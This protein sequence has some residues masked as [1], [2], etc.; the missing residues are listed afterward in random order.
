MSNIRKCCCADSTCVPVWKW[1]HDCEYEK[2]TL[3]ATDVM[4]QNMYSG[5]GSLIFDN[6]NR[7]YTVNGVS[8]GVVAITNTGSSG[9][10]YRLGCGH[11]EL[12]GFI[13]DAVNYCGK[14]CIC[15]EEALDAADC[16]TINRSWDIIGV[17]PMPSGFDPLGYSTVTNA[18]SGDIWLG[19]GWI[20]AT[21]WTAYPPASVL[22]A[23]DVSDCCQTVCN[24]QTY[25]CS[26]WMA[27]SQVNY[28]TVAVD[29]SGL[30]SSGTF[31][32][33]P[34]DSFGYTANLSYSILYSYVSKTE[35]E[36]EI[37]VT[38]TNVQEFGGPI[39]SCGFGGATQTTFPG[40]SGSMTYTQDLS[41]SDPF[42]VC[43]GGSQSWNVAAVDQ[44]TIAEWC[45][46][47]LGSGPV[48]VFIMKATGTATSSHAA[49]SFGSTTT[50]SVDMDDMRLNVGGT[51]HFLQ[52]SAVA[53]V[54]ITMP[55]GPPCP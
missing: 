17:G 33:D 14:D 26:Q 12:H 55:E 20:G 18:N 11:F 34:A 32:Q 46:V 42:D 31:K 10:F 37:T 1:V 5:T 48:P 43:N 44:P 4:W 51:G 36:L 7:T 41:A 6:E 21:T 19:R 39:F 25:T 8:N 22:V 40:G 35:I 38:F 49:L 15:H 29:A 24:P 52:E 53:D 28:P 47:D 9:I 23:E 3:Y 2:A 50:I 30:P 54:E 13:C 45:Y 27:K 16:S